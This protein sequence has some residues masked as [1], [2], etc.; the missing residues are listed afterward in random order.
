MDWDSDWIEKSD[1][2]IVIVTRKNLS[3]PTPLTNEK[4]RNHSPNRN[5]KSSSIS[6]IRF[7][8][9]LCDTP[10][11]IFWPFWPVSALFDR[12]SSYNYSESNYIFL[13]LSGFFRSF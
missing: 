12:H 8:S 7:Y 9:H 3:Y 6:G 5:P 10:N 13:L 4:S 2:Q 11:Q 1:Q